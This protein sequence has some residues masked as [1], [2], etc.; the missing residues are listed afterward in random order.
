MMKGGK[1][2][3]KSILI[4]LVIVVSIWC[5]ACGKDRKVTEKQIKNDIQ[6]NVYMISD[7]ALD[8]DSF[9]IVSRRTDAEMKYDQISVDIEASNSDFC[10]DA[11]VQMR[12]GLYDNGWVLDE[13]NVVDSNYKAL[14][15]CD[16]VIAENAIFEDHPQYS[17]QYM[18]CTS[19]ENSAVF[20]YFAV[21]EPNSIITSKYAIEVECIYSPDKGWHVDSYDEKLVEEIWDMC[22]TYFVKNEKVDLKVTINKFNID[23]ENNKIYT[24]FDYSF[25]S[26][27][28]HDD[29]WGGP[30]MKQNQEYSSTIETTLSFNGKGA[31]CMVEDI[32]RMYFCAWN[33]I[34]GQPENG[35]K[36]TIEGDYATTYGSYWLMKQ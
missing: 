17:L 8:I 18:D 15:V 24:Q 9:E 34:E 36:V 5:F 20:S 30:S 6:N 22:G 11:Q 28:G 19:E 29:W 21:N 31:S 13:C 26:Y 33:N 14:K 23:V 4:L 3:K 35:I 32:A 2:V 25:V 16:K 1:R 12:Y 7:Y 27:M 10:L